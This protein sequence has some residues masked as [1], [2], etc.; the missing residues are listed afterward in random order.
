[1]VSFASGLTRGRDKATL[2]TLA[3][4]PERE[5]RGRVQVKRP[6][7][8]QMRLSRLR[9]PCSLLTASG[10]ASDRSREIDLPPHQ[11]AQERL[12]NTYA[13]NRA[14]RTQSG[15]RCEARN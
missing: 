1:M 6:S 15:D 8:G 2:V 4:I 14:H 9:S 3:F 10:I 7:L 11:E 12:T 5:P 13:E